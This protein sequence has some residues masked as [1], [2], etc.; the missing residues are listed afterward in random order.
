QNIEQIK[1][2]VLTLSYQEELIYLYNL[3]KTI[4][5]NNLH[6]YSD[7]SIVYSQTPNIRTSIGWIL[8][9]Q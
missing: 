1:N 2:I 7:A 3:I 9:N 4:P 8:D 5:L 6:F